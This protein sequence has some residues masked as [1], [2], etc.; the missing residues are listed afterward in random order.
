MNTTSAD[1]GNVR[2]GDRRS[3]KSKLQAQIRRRVLRCSLLTEPNLVS[4]PGGDSL[5]ARSQA[6]Y[7]DA[8]PDPP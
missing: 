2:V 8:L 3:F 7:R 4:M 6:K 5:R 1:L